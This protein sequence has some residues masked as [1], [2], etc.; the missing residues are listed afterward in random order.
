M[1]LGVQVSQFVLEFIISGS[2]PAPVIVCNSPPAGAIG[3][4]YTHAFP[5][6]GGVPPYTLFQITAGSLPPGLTLDPATGIV[7][8]TPTKSGFYPFTIQVTDSA[9]GTGSVACSITIN[10]QVAIQ[11]LGWKLYPKDPCAEFS[12]PAKVEEVEQAV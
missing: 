3:T 11:L 10:A 7:S 12:E 6:S 2:N 9:A 8:G 1:S 4:A 5:A